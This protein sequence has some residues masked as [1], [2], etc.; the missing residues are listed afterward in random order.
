MPKIITG[1]VR[2]SYAHLFQPKSINGSDPKYSASL[3]IPK[4]DKVTLSKIKG[5]VDEAIEEGKTSKWNG[6]VPP[7]LKLPLRDGDEDRPD[8][9]VYE[10]HYFV[11]ANSPNKPGI[12]KPNPAWDGVTKEEK[13]EMIVDP[14]EVYSGCYAV[15]SISI[16]PFN[17]NGNRGVGIGLNHVLKTREGE[18]LGGRSRAEDDFADLDLDLDAGFLD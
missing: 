3:L 12:V 10:G 4:S 16:Y 18:P 11:N 2:L 8:D 15:A 7:N 5:A 17:A 1:E 14:T 13:Y 6:K 9:E